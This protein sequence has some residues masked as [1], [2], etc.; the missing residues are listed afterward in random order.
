MKV[1]NTMIMINPSFNRKETEEMVSEGGADQ[2]IL[3]DADLDF[4][5]HLAQILESRRRK[6]KIL[7]RLE[8]LEGLFLSYKQFQYKVVVKCYG[9]S[10][11]SGL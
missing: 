5:D 3:I 9:A 8:G 1:V 4:A 7:R 10:E 2:F 11:Q 6:V